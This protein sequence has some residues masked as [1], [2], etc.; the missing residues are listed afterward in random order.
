MIVALLTTAVVTPATAAPTDASSEGLV[1]INELANGGSRSDSDT[2]FELRN[3]GDTAVDLTGWQVF[4]CSTQGLRSNIGRTEGD[5]AGVVL[6]PGEIY[7]VSKIGMPG[8]AHISS[9]YMTGGFG[10]YLENP[11]DQLADAVGVYPNEPWPTTSECTLGA[12]LPNSLAF[13]FDESWQRIAATGSVSADFV[14]APA[15]I[16]A[17]N[18]PPAPVAGT[19]VIISEFA[20]SGPSS[21]DDEFVEL[22]NLSPESIDIGDWQLYRCTATGRLRQDTLQVTLPGDTSL[23]AGA[24]YVIAANGYDGEAD[25]RYST[26]FADVTSGALLVTA[27][28]ERADGIAVSAYAD[29]ACQSGDT[30]L[31]AVLDHVNAESYQFTAKGFVIATR[32]PGAAAGA[33]VTSEDFSYQDVAIS[34]FATDPSNGDLPAGTN[35]QNYL[36]LGNYGST[37]VDLSGWTIRRCEATGIRSR[38]VQLT[39]DSGT[40]L[41]P[42]D[43]WLAAKAGTVV[44]AD[45][46]YGSAFNFLGAGAWVE[47]ASGDRVDSIGVYA[48][49]EMDESHVTWS[50]CSKGLPLTTYQPD[51]WLGETFQRTRFTGVDADDF[52]V[53]PATPGVLDEIPWV[54]PTERVVGDTFETTASEVEPV[55]ALPATSSKATL[56]EAWSGL[57]D[58][59]LSEKQGTDETALDPLAPAD[60]ADDAYAYPYQRFVLDAST[61]E[62]GSRVY[63]SGGAVGRTELQLSVWSDLGWRLLDVGVGTEMRLSGELTASE[64]QSD[65]VTLLVQNG[66]RTSATLSSGVDGQLED[67]ADYDLAISHITD[68]QYLTESYPE[69]Y[70]QLVSWIADNAAGRK[71]EFATHTGDLVQNWVDPDQGLDRATVEFERASAIQSIL[72]EAGIPNSVLPGNHDNKRGVD[73]SLFNEYFGPTRYPSS[74]PIAPDDNTSNYTTFDHDGAQFLMLSL[75]YAY[76]DREIEWASSVVTSHP[77][78]NVIISTHEHVTP[79]TLIE[80]AHVSVNSRW[81][82]RGQDLWDRVIAPNR[83]VSIVLSGHFHGLGQIRTENAG[84]I[85][86]HDVVELLADYQ[87]FRTHSGERATGF[88]RLLQ[89]DLASS[90]V[91]VDTFSVGLDS[92][93]SFEYDYPQFLPDT[94]QSNS[95]SNARPWNIVAI[96]LQQR[97][98]ADDDEFQASVSFQYPKL[99]STRGL[100]VAPPAPSSDSPSSA[101]ANYADLFRTSA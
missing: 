84:G 26:G 98:T 79:K 42:G 8:D 95:A 16:G 17:A 27:A 48:M 101:A 64:V 100:D 57:S 49:N 18:V 44:A 61:L 87:E 88:Q 7:T 76:G 11:L 62:A 72:D 31:P 39:I 25:A 1:L 89:L 54:D 68:T 6:E 80:D 19:G 28:G 83:N 81:V 73:D 35:Q 2:F 23:A 32:T 59:P 36:E 47:D 94:G 38:E 69:V 71:I 77:D 43:T 58:A 12:N 90:T 14:K 78:Y 86:G 51:R 70:A 74:T 24:R 97:Y 93:T 34:E 3:W 4:R 15:T 10:L 30:K 5:L 52:V 45:A 65:T 22:W 20:P 56:L 13:G 92:T 91:A 41:K 75:G 46:T 53:A 85:E 9:P 66:P 96:G 33:A 40:T 21:T 29:S 63:W 50:P 99:V 60:M 82:S 37:T 55:E 67:P